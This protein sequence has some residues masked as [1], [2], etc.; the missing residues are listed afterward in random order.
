ML[1]VKIKLGF[2]DDKGVHNKGEVLDIKD[3]A[4]NPYLMTVIDETIEAEEIPSEKPKETPKK[5]TSKK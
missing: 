5:R 2:V 4:F 3:E 1:K